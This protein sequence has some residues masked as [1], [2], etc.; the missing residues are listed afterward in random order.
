GVQLLFDLI[1]RWEKRGGNHIEQ[2]D[3]TRID[4]GEWHALV[5]K[6]GGARFGD[7]LVRLSM[8][9]QSDNP[10]AERDDFRATGVQEARDLAGIFDRFFFGCEA[11][12]GT[13]GWAFAAAT[14]PFGA[15]LRPVLG[16]AIGHWDVRD[17]RE[18]VP[19]AYELLDDG[20]L[21][22]HQFR[23]FACDNPIRLH[24]RMN[25][26]FFDGTPVATYARQVPA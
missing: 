2:L 19:E 8:L 5:D 17:M 20:R 4:V 16:S 22:A 10:P 1:G 12:E 23:A 7:E 21:D 3:P 9:A 15:G 6:Y 25:P 18:V 11:D 14:N 26:A 13:V 24:A